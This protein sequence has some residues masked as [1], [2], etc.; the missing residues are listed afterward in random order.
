MDRDTNLPAV[1]REDQ[2]DRFRRMVEYEDIPVTIDQT[3]FAVGDRVRVKYGPLIDRE[4]ELVEVS[5]KKCVAVSLGPLGTA[6]IDLPLS[7]IE[8]L[9]KEE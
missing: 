4:C 2:L 3:V 8:L 9:N 1:V 5:G 6:R 7:Q